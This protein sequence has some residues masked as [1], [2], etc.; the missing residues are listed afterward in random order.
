[1]SRQTFSHCVPHR[2]FRFDRVVSM[3]KATSEILAELVGQRVEVYRNLNRRCWS[4][5]CRGKV[6]AHLDRVWLRD[7]RWVVQPAGRERVLNSGQNNVHA[8]G[9]GELMSG[10]PMGWLLQA[11]R[12][13]V[14]YNPFRSGSFVDASTGDEVSRHAVAVFDI[15]QGVSAWREAV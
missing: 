2:A 6:V 3:N 13:Q 9:R 15:N 10:P 1:M 4:V 7:C 12:A 14:T 5:R 8:F 11:H